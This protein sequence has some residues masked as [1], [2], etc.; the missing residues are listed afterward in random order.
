MRKTEQIEAG[1]G[2]LAQHCLR[3]RKFIKQSGVIYTVYSK[4]KTAK[5]GRDSDQDISDPVAWGL[6]TTAQGED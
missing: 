2:G 3:P 4:G 1:S 5:V 6:I